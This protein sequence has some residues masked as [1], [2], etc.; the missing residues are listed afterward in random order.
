VD[1]TTKGWWIVGAMWAATLVAFGLAYLLT[2]KWNRKA[3]VKRRLLVKEDGQFV[4][5]AIRGKCLV[6]WPN[7]KSEISSGEWTR[8]VD[9]NT[10]EWAVIQAAKEKFVVYRFDKL[11]D[12]EPRTG[13]IQICDSWRD[14]EST[15]PPDIFERALLEAG[16]N[17][18]SQ[19][20]EVP[21]EL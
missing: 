14:L 10:G 7:R 21:L 19:Y 4:W 9:A 12:N 15:L 16:F 2:R 20:R 18:P 8:R 5:R 1:Q 6:G 13:V 17:K 3:M 11:V